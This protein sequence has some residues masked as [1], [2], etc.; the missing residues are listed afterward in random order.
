MHM[1]MRFPAGKKR[2]FT[3]SYDDGVTPDLHLVQIMRDHGVRGTFNLIS[4][5]CEAQTQEQTYP[6]GQWGD[7]TAAQCRKVAG[8]DM[9]LAVHTR[10]HPFLTRMPPH[11]AMAEVLH[12]REAIER[13]TGKPVRG[14]AYPYGDYNDS[15]VALLQ[16][17]G[18]AYAR[19]CNLNRGDPFA[20]PVDWLRMP[21]TCHHNDTRLMPL[22]D[23]F[24]APLSRYGTPKLFYLWGHSYEFEKDGNWDRI[25]SFLDRM[26]GHDSDVWYATNIEI[27]DYVQAYQRLLWT[28]D[29]SV[30]QNP[31]AQDVWISPYRLGDE[32]NSPII[33]IP[34]GQTVRLNA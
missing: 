1:V 16:Q 26:G 22:I 7:M 18:M 5:R 3:M 12:D 23:E 15:I 27:Y 30:V 13:L 4:S 25:E 32:A 2:A 8:S 24:F 34:A 20:V 31:S 19:T 14:M 21:T 10:T 11:V 33:R 17:A 9:E 6:A 28:T 29:F